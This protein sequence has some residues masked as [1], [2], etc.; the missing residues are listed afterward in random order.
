MT[1]V[2]SGHGPVAPAD[3]HVIATGRDDAVFG[4]ARSWSQV[5]WKPG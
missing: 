4:R 3:V 2:S 1:G 5:W